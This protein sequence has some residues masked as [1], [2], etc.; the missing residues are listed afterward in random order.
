MN[1]RIMRGFFFCALFAGSAAV[2]AGDRVRLVTFGPDAHPGKGDDD[3]TEVV[4]IQVPD[5]A[6]GPLYLRLWDP[7][8]GGTQDEPNGLWNG[9]TRFRLFGGEGAFSQAGPSADPSAWRSVGEVL[10]E[11]EFGEDA[12]TDGVWH[13]LA[14]FSP[15]RGE[16]VG[17]HRLFRL[18]VEGVA[19]DDGNL[20]D[21]TVSSDA[22]TNR[23][24]EGLRLLDYRPT[25][26]VSPGPERLAEAVFAV[27]AD[28]DTLVIRQFDLDRARIQLE[29]PIVGPVPLRSSGEARWEE[30]RVAIDPGLGA[31]RAA[32]QVR[33]GRS[34][35]NDVVLEARDPSGVPLAF[36]LPIRLRPPSIPPEPRADIAI[37]DDCLGVSF[38]AGRSDGRD[39]ALIGYLWDF[40]DGRQASGKRV[41]HRYEEPGL[42][43]VS[44]TAIDDS[45]RVM[46][47]ARRGYEVKVN[48]SP[49]AVPGP[50]RTLAPGERTIFDA[51][52]SSDADGRITG[53]R[54]DF[55]DGAEGQGARVEHAFER[56]GR[57]PVRL[58]VEDDGPGPCTRTGAVTQVW[59]NAPPV[60]RAGDDLRAAV[61]EVLVLDAGGSGDT[62]GELIR[63]HWDLG[64]GRTAEGTR[65][66]TF[67]GEPGRYRVRLA[68]EDD[69]GVGNSRSED[70]LL[71]WINAPPLADAS[72][73]ERGAVDQ[74]LSFDA[75]ASAD[76]D[77]ALV[78]YLWDFGDGSQARGVRVEHAYAAPGR[79]GVRLEIRDD[80]GT[81]SATAG[82]GLEVVVND[83]P[84]ADAGADVWVTASQVRFDGS[85][86]A[87]P[88]GRILGYVWDFG[89]GTQGEGPAPAH[90]YA[91]PGTYDVVLTVTDD[92]GTSSAS[93]SDGMRVRIN[94]GPVADAGPDRL[95]APDETIAF[96]GTGSF[97]PDGRI[98]D[99]AW[100][101]GDGTSASGASPDH[102]YA[103]PGLYQVR[104]RVADD[105]GHP[106]AF[107]VAEASVRVNAAPVA[108][109]GPDVLAAPDQEIRLDG[110]GSHDPDGR[111]ASYRWTLDEGR[112]AGETAQVSL[113]FAKPGSHVARLEVVDDSGAANGHA[114][115]RLS[116]RI[117]HRPVAAAG[118]PIRTC[119]TRV[120]FD[121]GGSSDADGDPLG[122]S[123]SFGDTGPGAE[124]PR[125]SHRFPEGGRYPVVL[126]VDDG[127]GLDNATQSAST[128]VWIHR[129]PLAVIEAPDLVCA[130][131]TVLFNGVGS[132][133]P[134]G[135]RLLYDWDF[136][137]GSGSS[138]AIP[139]KAFASGGLYPVTLKVRDDSGL[140]C[141]T[142]TARHLV[143]V[144]DAP[145]AEAGEDV[146]ICANT[147]LTFDGTGSR[148]FDGVVNAYRW[149]F[150]DGTQGG[151]PNPTHL[152][153]RAG[154][155]AVTLTITGDRVGRCDN[156]HSDRLSVSVLDAPE[157][158]LS[159]PAG[160]ALGAPAVLTANRLGDPD[161]V[162]TPL[163]YGWDLGDGARADG[164]RV[165]HLYSEPGRYLVTMT[166]DDGSGG[167]CGRV[168]LRHAIQVNA[169]P[170]P[171][172]G[173]D[174]LAAPGEILSFDASASR[175]PDGAIRR[176]VWDFGDGETAEG[177]QATHV[178][179]EPGDYEVEL[180]VTDDT[181][182]PNASRSDRIAVRCN[183]AP[184][185]AFEVR[186][187]VLC[188]GRDGVL[189]AGA[190]SDPEGS[191]IA[192][193]WD[194]GDGSQ[195][196]GVEVR[197]AYAEPG[198]YWV[199]LAVEDD[200]G[201]SNSRAALGRA[202]RVNQVP[203]ARLRS[204]LMGCPGE[205]IR[206]SG[207]RS[208][209]P[210]GRIARY[211]W[212]FG[213]GSGAEG[214][215]VEHLYSDPG[216][217]PLVLAVTDDSGS[218]CARAERHAEVRVN[219][220]P[221][222]EIRTDSEV[223]YVGG[224][225]DGVLFDATGSSDPDGDALRF[226][227]DF[228]DG[229][230]A[231]GAQVRH[232]FASPGRYR[233][234]L[235]V[236]DDSGTGCAGARAS[237]EIEVK[238]ER[239]GSSE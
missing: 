76:P 126:S 5:S 110:S 181:D 122:Y 1:S 161:A 130:G 43:R 143:Q 14:R 155:Y 53:Y 67:Y 49:I 141:D 100:D 188:P 9:R 180:T 172:A 34:L 183:A 144:V 57:Y 167:D 199:R 36:E 98:R 198:D 21:L 115:D 153:T 32:V 200:A 31:E 156:R 177:L 6:A 157:V 207:L 92:S 44:L 163:K 219:A 189:D 142:A 214:A 84:V 168:T 97:D 69:A 222:A 193:H 63:F 165:E 101:F 82:T 66:E 175:D 119:E 129:R 164:A 11:A 111:I 112:P 87:D 221:K 116:I 127:T 211:R 236:E 178:Y 86:S 40:G 233:V 104:L 184:V 72:G 149:D 83:P 182:L 234:E 121:G 17:G 136:G 239:P 140:D 71:I 8:L 59:V 212:D 48:R 228:G 169:P 64:D 52:A 213:D 46:D 120:A 190:S 61:G 187:P 62:D 12:S 192:W 16:E 114:E 160:V 4:Y 81:T 206:F 93:R 41:E 237:V 2:Q 196:E 226:S 176:Y 137:D 225:H 80:S 15:E 117:N 88:D 210:D 209:D 103:E 230:E 238:G 202:L 201:V 124:G 138:S 13:T 58:E 205:P 23:P 78:E 208:S 174:R 7:D 18:L 108:L 30:E 204:P 229:G 27:P 107:D 94:A 65:V 19:G 223:A 139:A 159:A 26:S 105:S 33:G 171:D 132:S 218:D 37:L 227:W 154:D 135:G 28:A 68:V 29:L 10:G 151:G 50:E 194:L 231:L 173:G 134:D 197:H 147:P 73:P 60:A 90:V 106:Q 22:G 186:P 70:D 118:A 146:R 91:L 89:D 191:P 96:D 113:R 39:D 232:A 217:Y 123:W 55:G 95:V 185:P 24:V 109:A 125:V 216:R 38:D 75:S 148:D 158:D 131:E 152:Y 102:A 45:G 25:F 42:Y 20:Y 166:A 235:L 74:T 203:D 85:G 77:G 150:G 195:A 128:Q 170:I 215:E 54:W 224:A 51:S 99:Y 35:L 3:F 179:R 133:D 56:P 220:A 145:V 79:Y 162:G 47:R